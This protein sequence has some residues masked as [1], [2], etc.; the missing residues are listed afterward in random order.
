M[1]TE[2]RIRLSPPEV[3]APRKSRLPL[4][5]AL[6]WLSPYE[7]DRM[8]PRVTVFVRP[9]AYVRI[10]AHAGSDLRNEVGGGLVGRWRADARTG[11]QFIVVEA[12]IPA[13]HVRHGSTYLTFTQDTLVAMHDD[14]GERYPNKELVG[15]YHTHPRMGIFLSGYDVWLHEHFFPELWQV[16]LVIEPH[17]SIGG[18]F[19]RQHDGRLDPRRYFGFYE[20]G[21]D[22]KGS[23][24]HWG[25]LSADGAIASA[26]GGTQS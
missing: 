3:I 20:L 23:V 21:E 10:C 11:E 6:R 8:K 12:A 19:A 22:G 5:A 2:S 7:D 24:V 26:E 4:A 9:K 16:A 14:L 25:N 18:I 17:T 1:A 13:R 15:W